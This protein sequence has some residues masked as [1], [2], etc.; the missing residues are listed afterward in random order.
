MFEHLRQARSAHHISLFL[1]DEEL[2]TAAEVCAQVAQSE[3]DRIQ[4]VYAGILDN[5]KNGVMELRSTLQL[6]QRAVRMTM[7]E[8]ALFGGESEEHVLLP[9]YTTDPGPYLFLVCEACNY[10][11]HRCHF[12]GDDLSH[13]EDLRL[14]GQIHACYEEAERELLQVPGL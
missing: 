8:P 11:K 14:N 4:L 6:Q 7:L 1:E 12:C 2:L 9:F 5:I 3:I 13:A 10:V